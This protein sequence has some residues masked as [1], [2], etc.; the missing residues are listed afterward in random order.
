M[1]FQTMHCNNI[2]LALLLS[3]TGVSVW[4]YGSLIGQIFGLCHN[5][6]TLWWIA[7]ELDM[8]GTS[9]VDVCDI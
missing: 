2:A 7:M 3:Y 8:H 4:L 1:A 5:L 9:G 6:Q